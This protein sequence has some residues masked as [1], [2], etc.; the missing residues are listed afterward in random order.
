MGRDPSLLSNRSFTSRSGGKNPASYA[1]VPARAHDPTCTNL[2]RKELRL[3]YQVWAIHNHGILEH[4]WALY[5]WNDPCFTV[6]IPTSVCLPLLPLSLVSCLASMF[7]PPRIVAPLLYL[8]SPSLP[9][10]P[11]WQSP[12]LTT[13]HPGPFL[14]G[15]ENVGSLQK[16]FEYDHWWMAKIIF[17]VDSR[18][19]LLVTWFILILISFYW[20]EFCWIPRYTIG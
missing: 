7:H 10:V 17:L 15:K 20:Y 12:P 2:S 11:W 5:Q 3:S 18:W 6:T 16:Q 14:Q 9:I 8:Y 4:K 19:R 1:S 13:R